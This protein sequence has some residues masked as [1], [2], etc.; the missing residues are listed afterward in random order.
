MDGHEDWESATSILDYPKPH[1][2][3]EIVRPGEEM[4]ESILISVHEMLHAFFMLSRSRFCCSPS[5]DGVTGHGLLYLGVGTGYGKG[6]Q[7]DL[8]RVGRE[9]PGCP[10]SK[11]IF[12]F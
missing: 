10:I 5:P 3:I 2:L 9:G 7:P 4:D 12:Q 11:R 6:I 1:V 8:Q